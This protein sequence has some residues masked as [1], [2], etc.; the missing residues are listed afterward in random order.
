MHIHIT[1]ASGSGTT[2]LGQAL[3]QALPLRHLDADDYY[4]LPT[5]PP[6][7][8][9]RDAAERLALLDSG[10]ASG[11][12]VVLSGSIVGWGD[13]VE[14]A[15]GLI[16]FLYL[17]ADIRLER[18]RQREVDRHGAVD[19]AFLQWAAQYDGGTAEGRSLGKHHAWLAQRTC[20]VLRLQE[21]MP[22]HERVARV[23]AALP[24]KPADLADWR[25][26][27]QERY[28]RGAL[29]EWAQ[30]R[31]YRPGWEHDHCEF[32]SAEFSLHGA[33]ALREGYATH[34]RYRW[35]CA[36]C[37]QDFREPMALRLE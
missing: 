4:W 21:D 23:L 5:S 10:I 26:F 8:H 37:F 6:F 16:V 3:A 24:P 13:A 12:A 9:K 14:N 7:R 31:P 17:P 22:V 15:F 20:P 34:D 25:L 2:T 1:G 27:G 19:P 11:G 35:V 30:Y 32:C 29:F 36:Q 18:L 28:M 33:D